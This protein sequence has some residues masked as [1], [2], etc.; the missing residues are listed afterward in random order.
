MRSVEIRDDY[1][2]GM[3]VIEIAQKYGINMA[4]VRRYLK[5]FYITPHNT[6]ETYPLIIKYHLEGV[7]RDDIAKR[8]CTSKGFVTR[9][10]ADSGVEP[11][12]YRGDVLEGLYNGVEDNPPMWMLEEFKR[13]H[14]L[15]E[16]F[17]W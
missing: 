15:P 16:G 10:L 8:C 12:I 5:L 2:D 3:S 11:R 7:C 17:D 13:L 4:K 1:H 9:L 6:Y 14:V